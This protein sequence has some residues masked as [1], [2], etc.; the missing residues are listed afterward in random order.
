MLRGPID[1]F[2]CHACNVSRISMFPSG[3]LLERS[4]GT[5]PAS[6]C[7]EMRKSE[8]AEPRVGQGIWSCTTL[9]R[10]AADGSARIRQGG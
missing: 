5:R 3:A 4:A 8:I 9:C 10:A 7:R 2:L 6:R 1:R